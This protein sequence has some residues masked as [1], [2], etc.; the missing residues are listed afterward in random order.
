MHKYQAPWKTALH[1][2]RSS[3]PDVMLFILFQKGCF[4]TKGSHPASYMDTSHSAGL[5][6]SLCGISLAHN[7]R[8]APLLRSMHPT[9]L[10]LA[11]YVGMMYMHTHVFT[12]ATCSPPCTMLHTQSDSATSL[13]AQIQQRLQE[14]QMLAEKM[15]RQP[16]AHKRHTTHIWTPHFC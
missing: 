14:P 12:Y 11:H 1:R 9:T 4:S 16:H 2:E 15:A 8:E 5:P 10:Q 6:H 3:H 7:L 13:S